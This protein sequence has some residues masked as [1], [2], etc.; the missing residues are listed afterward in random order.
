MREIRFHKVNQPYG[1]FSNFSPHPIFLDNE[2]WNTV[3][4]YFQASKFNDTE[5]R[6]K[7]QL[8]ESPMEAAIEGR[9]KKNILREDWEL[10]KEEFMYKA[11]RC[12][13]TQHPKL[14]HNLMLTQDCIIIE[15]TENDNYWGDGG[16]G[17]GQNRLG[18]LLMQVRNELAKQVDDKLV[19]LP[20]WIAFPTISQHDLFWRMG[21]GEEYLTQWSKYYLATNKADYKNKYPE[22]QEWEGIYD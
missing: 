5:I 22:N 3:E 16:D 9:D 13:F 15:H 12:K 17:R 21:L 19:V 10:V 4:H 8:M 1:Y 7:I 2:I 18:I 11:L 6:R 20:P 14:M